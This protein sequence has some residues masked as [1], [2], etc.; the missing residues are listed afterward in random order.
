MIT[1]INNNIFNSTERLIVHQTNCIGVMGGGIALQIKRLYREVYLEYL[2]YCNSIKDKTKLLGTIQ[3][4]QLLIY[5][6]N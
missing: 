3:V 2:T 6:V 5:L 1:T 4:V